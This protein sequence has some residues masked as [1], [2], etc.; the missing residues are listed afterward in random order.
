MKRF[1]LFL[2]VAVACGVPWVAPAGSLLTN[3]IVFVSPRLLDFGAVAA[4]KVATN[5]VVVEN[6]GGGRLIGA[7]KVAAPF[8]ILSGGS[9]N[10]GRNEAQ[11]ITVTYQPGTTGSDSQPITFTG[12]GG[13][14]VVATGHLEMAPVPPKAKK[15]PGWR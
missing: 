13:A 4:G 2:A 6:A 8:K 12:G 10:L 1:A 5:T 3:P 14:T 7:A 9:Y 11:V 15:P